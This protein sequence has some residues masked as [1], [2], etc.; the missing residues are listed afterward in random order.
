MLKYI[1]MNYYDKYLKYK[2]KYKNLKKKK[3]VVIIIIILKNGL[4]KIMVKVN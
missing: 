4:K 3:L 2:N 1:V